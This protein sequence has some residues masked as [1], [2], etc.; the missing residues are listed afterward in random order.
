[1]LYL[2][3]NLNELVDFQR[4]FLIGVEA[5]AVQPPEK[6]QFGQLFMQMVSLYELYLEKVLTISLGREIFSL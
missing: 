6:Q 5:N 2:F 4:K 3:A 1:M